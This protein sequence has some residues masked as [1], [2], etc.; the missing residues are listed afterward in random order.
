M[1]LG[2]WGIWYQQAHNAVN[3]ELLAVYVVL[4]G[5]PGVLAI[6]QLIRGQ[7]STGTESE[8]PPSP[9]RP[10]PSPSS[11][12]SAATTGGGDP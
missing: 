8:S 1:A 7:P 9:D 10:R 6:V 2:V 11:P 5:G 3:V 12:S 4:I